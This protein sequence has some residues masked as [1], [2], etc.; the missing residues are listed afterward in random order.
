M[1]IRNKKI[2]TIYKEVLDFCKDRGFLR[3]L[4]KSLEV[5]ESTRFA[6]KNINR[7]GL[8]VM[9]VVHCL[10]DKN[11]TIL[12][13]NEILSVSKKGDVILEAGIGTGILSIAGSI[14]SKIVYGY[15]INKNVYVLAKQIKDYLTRKRLIKDNIIYN[16]LDAKNID[17]KN[18]AD[19]II[20]ENLYTGMFFEKQIQIVRNLKKFLKKDGLFVP[21]GI[22]SSFVLSETISRGNGIEDKLYI[23][24]ENRVY[25]RR[26]SDEVVYD[27][28]RFKTID[29]NRL[30]F[31]KKVLIKKSGIV[32][33]VLISSEV[34]LPSGKVIGR[35]DTE[36]MNNDIII[37]IDKPLKVVRGNVVSVSIKYTYGSDPR[38]AKIS[39]N[40]T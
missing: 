32:N 7:Y 15:E 8:D 5:P 37:M 23:V 19:V 38:I 34:S 14:K 3:E 9:D 27:D 20:S 12:L 26:L 33:S 39:I 30:I 29:S 6:D 24:S 21:S 13:V 22:K 18:K 16:L 28:I 1:K 31:S 25:S 35:D 10:V 36:F 11:R 4:N 2:E 17:V 40:I